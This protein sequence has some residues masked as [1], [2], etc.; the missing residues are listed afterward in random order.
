MSARHAAAALLW[1][2]AVVVPLDRAAAAVVDDAATN[3]QILV[4]LRTAP[5]HF[6]PD[7]SYSG[8]YDVRAGRD[9]RRR[10]AEALAARFDLDI[11]ENWPMPA[12]GVDC[13]VMAAADGDAV[14]RIVL[15]VARDPR[16]ESVQAMHEFHVLAH[17]DSL[18]PLQPSARAW[19]LADVHKIATGSKVSV[20]EIDTG[21]ERNHPDLAGRVAVARNFVDSRDDVAEIHGTAVAGIIAARA[22]DGI[23]VAGIAP[24]SRLMALRACWETAA[25]AICNSFTV[26][27]ALQFALDEK[28]QVIN[29]SLGGPRDRLLERLLD[30]AAARGV[31]VVAAFDPS[32]PDGGFPASHRGVLAV[33]A[34]DVHDTP[35]NVLLA[36]GR[37]IPTTVTEGRWGFVT[38][39]SF[40]AAHVTGLVALMRELAPRLSAHEIREA[41][42]GPSTTSVSAG[43]RATID[44]CAAIARI[45]GVCAC[46]CAVSA[47]SRSAPLP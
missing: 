47:D 7:I 14:P 25:R 11:V 33:A 12:L 40:A 15:Q 29:L 43:H 9:G 38:G 39:S 8:S 16:V 36:P 26:A 10:T 3:R 28:A 35:A 34:D 18:Y 41:L 4:M 46:E 31:S 2:C 20:A 1:L 44:A 24:E 45:G 27:K 23:G 42:A 6:R 22:D 30:A 37:D 17:N 5:S 19:H 32:L 13:F 21:V